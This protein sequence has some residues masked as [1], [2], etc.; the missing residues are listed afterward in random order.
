MRT[1]RTPRPTSERAS[2]P[3]LVSVVSPT[4]SSVPI[5]SSSAVTIARPASARRLERGCI[6]HGASVLD[7]DAHR[8]LL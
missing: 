5:A 3:L 1:I 8:A 7:G 2:S 4:V 6:G